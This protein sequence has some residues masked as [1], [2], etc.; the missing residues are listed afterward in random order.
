MLSFKKV[1]NLD[2]DMATQRGKP[3]GETQGDWQVKPEGWVITGNPSSLTDLWQTTRSWKETI[4]DAPTGFQGRKA[5]PV[6]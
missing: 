3:S 6:P 5:L 4:E 2:M 1:E